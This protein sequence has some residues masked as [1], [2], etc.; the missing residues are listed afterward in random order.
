[1][2]KE[3][4]TE[5]APPWV[6]YPGADPW[7]GGW[8]QGYSETWLLDEWLPFWRTL[9]ELERKAYLARWPAPSDQ[10]RA[11]VLTLWK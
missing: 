5:L 10:W 7:W 6:A 11:Y 4:G 9:G 3:L 2:D 8:R 1:M